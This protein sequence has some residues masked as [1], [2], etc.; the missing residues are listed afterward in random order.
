M[1]L[2]DIAPLGGGLGIGLAIFFFLICLAAAFITFKMLKR[3]VKMAIRMVIVAVI[4]FVA[5]I[6][7]VALMYFG[8]SGNGPVKPPVKTTR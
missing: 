3:T 7:G 4:L 8:S 2:F 1:I 6:G 5:L